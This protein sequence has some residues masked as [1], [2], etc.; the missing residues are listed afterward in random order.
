MFPLLLF[1]KPAQEAL[2]A[3]HEAAAQAQHSYIGTEHLLVGLFA[4][5]DSVAAE[6]FRRR[7]I[8]REEVRQAVARV[9]EGNQQ[10]FV[11]QLLPTSRVKKVMGLSSKEAQRRGDTHVG[12]GDILV[13]ILSEG[14]GIAAYI[15]FDAGLTLADVRAEI[16][17]GLA[18]ESPGA[19]GAPW[20]SA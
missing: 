15:L 16:G 10:V 2:R 1:S 19:V 11:R 7:G 12:T 3:A 20:R 9:L 18:G 17:A 5:E 8:T 13:G 4:Q 14:D 6:V